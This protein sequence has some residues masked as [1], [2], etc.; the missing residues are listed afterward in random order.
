L[1]TIHLATLV[2]MIE[3]RLKKIEAKRHNKKFSTSLVLK[4]LK[5]FCSFIM[6]DCVHR[7]VLSTPELG[8]YV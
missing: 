7:Y 8:I 4:T 2:E 5:C 3:I 1:K 6:D